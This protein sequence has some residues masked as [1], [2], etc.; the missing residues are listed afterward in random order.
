MSDLLDF[1]NLP[2]SVPGSVNSTAGA[3]IANSSSSDG[4]IPQ[5]ERLFTTRS[6][7]INYLTGDGDRGQRAYIKLMTA[8]PTGSL[9]RHLEGYDVKPTS[10]GTTSGGVLNDSINEAQ[11]GGYANFLLT[12]VRCTL[13][14]KLQVIETFGDAEVSYYF[15]RQPIMMDFSGVLVDSSDN[16]WFIEWLEMYTNVMRGTQLARNYELIKIVLPNMTVIG[17]MASMSWG[18]NSSRDVDIPF[19]FRFLTKQ[20]IPQPVTLPS[21]PLTNDPVINWNVAS[22]FT[23]QSE[24]NSTK[25]KYGVLLQT[26]QNPLSTVS[27]YASSIMNIGSSV[28]SSG[29]NGIFGVGLSGGG[30]RV[31]PTAVANAPTGNNSL[32]SGVS[33]N[34]SGIRAS[35]FSPIYGVLSSLTKLIKG[36][37]GDI[38]S[39]VNSFVTPVRDILREIR[40]ISNQAIAIVN[41]VSN[42]INSVTNTV[43]NLDRDL[44]STLSLLKKT[45]GVITSA[46]ETIAQSLRNLVNSGKLPLTSK[47]LTGNTMT[48]LPNGS[49]IGTKYAL[50]NS[51]P[52]HTAE[53]GAKI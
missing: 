52:P 49:R 34:L 9:Q 13:E 12:D 35:L 16:N 6:R 14:E 7:G 18:Q 45:A 41:L 53:Q 37:A 32:F 39:V 23:S 4:S 33:S 40:T 25:S 11:Y 27:D 10:L 30:S 8:D 36:V 38:S 51:G 43:R 26:I 3:D 50:L 1:Q 15:G 20:I 24:I 44:Y 42:S 2:Q 28:S 22:Q 21:T 17:T 47:F 31:D 46:P 5:T 29:S 48:T 19:Q